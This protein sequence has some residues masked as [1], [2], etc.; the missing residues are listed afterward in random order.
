MLLLFYLSLALPFT[1][2]Y[3]EEVVVIIDGRA[4]RRC[5]KFFACQ[6]NHD[7]AQSQTDVWGNLLAFSDENCELHPMNV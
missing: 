1:V 3:D 6:S 4:C 7:G 2:D 5:Q